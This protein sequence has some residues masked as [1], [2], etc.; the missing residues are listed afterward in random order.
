MP[1]IEMKDDVMGFFPVEPKHIGGAIVKSTYAKPSAE[2]T[3]V[4]LNGGENLSAILEKVEPAGGKIVV[5]KTEIAPEHGYFALFLDT[6][7]NRVGLH[8][9]Q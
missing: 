6:E 5:E 1:R 3:I 2:G 9:L 4:Y 7:G 8:S